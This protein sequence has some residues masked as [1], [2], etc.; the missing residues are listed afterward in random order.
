MGKRTKVSGG[1]I[2]EPLLDSSARGSGP[3]RW[4]RSPSTPSRAPVGDHARCGLHVEHAVLDDAGA[5]RD[6]DV[7]VAG[8]AQVAAGAAVDTAL[9]RLEARR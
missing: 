2:S 4:L 9:D 7:H 1:A 8:K 3:R 6:R 5:D